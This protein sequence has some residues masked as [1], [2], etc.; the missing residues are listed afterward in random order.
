[1]PPNTMVRNRPAGAVGVPSWTTVT[2]VPPRCRP[3]VTGTNV[4]VIRY[5]APIPGESTTNRDGAT[6][7][8][9]RNSS[10][11]SPPS[12]AVRVSRTAVPV[13]NGPSLSI[14][15]RVTVDSQ[16]QRQ[17]KLVNTRQ[18]SST[19]A[20]TKRVT[21]TVDMGPPKLRLGHYGTGHGAQT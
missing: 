4:Y 3:S 20:A 17:L 16:S 1:M 10:L 7:S 5:S 8:R 21:A 14:S 12:A 18:T 2:M 9:T 11:T 19:G 13:P 6:H 15:T